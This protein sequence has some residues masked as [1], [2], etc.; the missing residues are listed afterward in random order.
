[1]YAQLQ[2]TAKALQDYNA[3]LD[4]SPNSVPAL[5][6]AGMTYHYLGDLAQAHQT[7]LAAQVRVRGVGPALWT[8]LTV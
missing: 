7:Y 6:N 8:P 3:A 1:M 2:E 4:R 5:I